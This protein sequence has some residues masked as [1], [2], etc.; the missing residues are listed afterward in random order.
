MLKDNYNTTTHDEF[1][2]YKL[3]DGLEELPVQVADQT[4]AFTQHA[5]NHNPRPAEVGHE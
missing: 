3:N 5:Y 2:P 4:S 1:K